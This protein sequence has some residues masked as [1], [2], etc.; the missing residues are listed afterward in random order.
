MSLYLRSTILKDQSQVTTIYNQ[1]TLLHGHIKTFVP[2]L[3]YIDETFL[4][5]SKEELSI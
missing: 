5:E 1:S 4:K 3:G 2:I